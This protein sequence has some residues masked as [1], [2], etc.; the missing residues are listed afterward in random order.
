M[1]ERLGLAGLQ[2]VLD[3][4]CFQLL[5]A[6]GKLPKTGGPHTRLHRLMADIME[7]GPGTFDA[8]ARAVLG[9][10]STGVK[11]G[12][13]DLLIALEELVQVLGEPTGLPPAQPDLSGDPHRL[14]APPEILE[15]ARLMQRWAAEHD[16][17]DFTVCGIGPRTH[18]REALQFFDH[19]NG[20]TMTEWSE[21]RDHIRTWFGFVITAPECT[22]GA[23]ALARRLDHDADRQVREGE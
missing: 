6:R 18:L 9:E 13:D 17:R 10:V 21:Q 14:L 2:W 7:T 12:A 8:N 4:V 11:Q 19:R 3:S 15:A 1:K 22:C 20:C 16:M 5:Q 23:I